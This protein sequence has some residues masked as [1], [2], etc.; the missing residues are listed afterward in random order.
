MD[1]KLRDDRAVS[2]QQERDIKAQKKEEKE[3]SG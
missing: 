1:E 3:E 2:R